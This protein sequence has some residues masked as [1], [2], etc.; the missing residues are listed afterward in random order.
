MLRMM[1][2]KEGMI[3]TSLPRS[4]PCSKQ[5]TDQIGYARDGFCSV[6]STS[7]DGMLQT[8]KY[9][10]LVAVTG[11]NRKLDAVTRALE[12]LVASQASR[13]LHDAED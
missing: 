10:Y 12:Q 6:T 8:I 13:V 5:F 4:S 11:M 3:R 1:A 7:N 2:V 9:S